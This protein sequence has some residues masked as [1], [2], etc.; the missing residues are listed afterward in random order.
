[1]SEKVVM[2]LVDGMRPDGMLQCGHPFVKELMEKSS[3][4]LTARTVFPSV[5]LPCHMSLFH[6]VDPDRHGITTNTYTPQVRPVDGIY[7]QLHLAKKSTAM[8]YTWQELRDLAR[9]D[10]VWVSV[11][12]NQHKYPDTDIAI[13]DAFL[14]YLEKERPDFTFLYLGETDEVGGHSCG[15]MS[16]QYEK[17]IY[18]AFDCIERVFRA[19]PQDYTLIV[20]ADHGGH[21]RGHGSDMPEDMT[22]P[23]LI[24]GKQFP[25]GKDLGEI[26][27]KDIA[28]T[29]VT[30]LD[31]QPAPEWEGKSLVERGECYGATCC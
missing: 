26:S 29:I 30:L 31:A 7:E 11:M 14:P 5:T 28:P 21:G 13:T 15:W 8:F 6:S 18:K 17:S 12:L 24:C 9:P 10:R 27:I 4:S 3:Y 19:L 20:L 16:E 2:I 25:A 23:V 22:I 1:M